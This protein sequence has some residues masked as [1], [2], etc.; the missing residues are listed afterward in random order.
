MGQMR[1]LRAG[2]HCARKERRFE[3]RAV[4]YEQIDS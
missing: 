1:E 2:P 3:L 4:S